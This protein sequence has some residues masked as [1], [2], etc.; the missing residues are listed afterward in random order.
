M[1]FVNSSKTLL[2]AG[3]LLTLCAL[4][5]AQAQ[6]K[7]GH[8]APPRHVNRPATHRSNPNPKLQELQQD[9]AQLGQ[10]NST[11]Q[12][13]L[14]REVA[15]LRAQMHQEEITWR[16]THRNA[17]PAEVAAMRRRL[18]GRYEMDLQRLRGENVHDNSMNKKKILP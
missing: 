14:R 15:Q 11:D 1:T 10:A 13:Q 16:R 5:P 7:P 18:Q 9:R 2:A 6:T 8:P 4:V 12:N 3:S 17:K